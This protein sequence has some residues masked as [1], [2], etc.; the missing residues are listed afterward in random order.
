VE[1][2]HGDGTITACRHPIEHDQRLL[3]SFVGNAT[4]SCL[5]CAG[6]VMLAA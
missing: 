6:A 5:W 3:H 1:I 2:D 4:P